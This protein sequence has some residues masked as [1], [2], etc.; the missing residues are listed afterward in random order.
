MMIALGLLTLVAGGVVFVV[1][2]GAETNGHAT[3]AS[4]TAGD[5][6][7]RMG[8]YQESYLGAW[9]SE[10]D[11]D[12]SAVSPQDV[13]D[14]W[15][16]LAYGVTGQRGFWRKTVPNEW[17]GCG[18]GEA[19]PACEAL[20]QA[21]PEFA[22]WDRFQE[23]LGTT[24]EGSARRFLARNGRKMMDYL[25]RYVPE[26]PTPSAMRE[27]AFFDDQLKEVIDQAPPS[28]ASPDLD[29]ELDDL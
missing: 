10:L 21:E 2:E 19:T 14:A 8:N 29:D 28:T 22:D 15:S 7:S 3:G 27:T 20:S 1:S 6:W 4:S 12:V 24:S 25:D 23:R 17:L 16:E 11:K 26:R 18:N 9:R 13:L 5:L